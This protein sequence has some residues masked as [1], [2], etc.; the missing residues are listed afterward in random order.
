[1]LHVLEREGLAGRVSVDSAGTH[2]YHVGEAPDSRSIRMAQKYGV[3][4]STQKARKVQLQ[5]F[6]E[7]D[8]I[9][10]LDAG[11]ERLLI[12]SC[13]SEY[14]H[15]VLLFLKH[16]GLAAPHDVPDPYYGGERDF[17]QAYRLIKDGCE[18][19][20]TKLRVELGKH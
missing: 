9:L 11:H 2:G 20:L 17:E 19:L 10:P 6:A 14:Q 5:D 4:I 18:G 15:K 13:P 12:Q 3:D 7:F 8:W 1:M 16:A